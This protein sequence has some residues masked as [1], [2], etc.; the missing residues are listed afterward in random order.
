MAA[1]TGRPHRQ[2]VL[3]TNGER[4]LKASAN[5]TTI[6]GTFRPLYGFLP[7]HLRHQQL[8]YNASRDIGAVRWEFSTCF[9]TID[10]Y[11]IVNCCRSSEHWNWKSY[12]HGEYPKHCGTFPRDP[13]SVSPAPNYDCGPS[14]T[15]P[16][17]LLGHLF[18]VALAL[19]ENQLKEFVGTKE[20]SYSLDLHLLGTN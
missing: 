11:Y 20:A 16:K 14:Q 1:H 7:L 8:P 6:F 19:E 15:R 17:V 9:A 4:K 10:S 18:Q 3:S 2:Q 5:K 13:S 12:N